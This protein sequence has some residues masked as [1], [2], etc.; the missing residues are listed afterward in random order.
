MKDL[1]LVSIAKEVIKVEIKSL[2]KLYLS[3]GKTFEK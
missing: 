2:N 1:D 3:V